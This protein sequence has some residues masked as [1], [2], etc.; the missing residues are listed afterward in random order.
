MARPRNIVRPVSL[1]TTFPEDIRGRLDLYLWSDVEN[2][3]PQGAYQQFLI[4]RIREF[5]EDASLDIGPWLAPV[6]PPMLIRGSPRAIDALTTY[7]EQKTVQQEI[8][9]NDSRKTLTPVVED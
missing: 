9:R 2:K 7:L 4:S 1:R 3:V 8:D 5:F 6:E